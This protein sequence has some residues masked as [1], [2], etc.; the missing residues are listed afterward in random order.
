MAPLRVAGRTVFCSEEVNPSLRVQP[1]VG[2]SAVLSNARGGDI[3]L[4]GVSE[5]A[6]G[7]W[8]GEKILW[9]ASLT[10]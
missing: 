5:A 7:A 9:A 3:S 8:N 4:P 10:Y 1:W 2:V 6:L